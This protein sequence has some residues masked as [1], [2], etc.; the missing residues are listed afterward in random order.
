MGRVRARAASK[1]DVALKSRA[2]RQR[3]HPRRARPCRHQNHHP[4]F[5]SAP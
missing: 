4:S 5:A 2:S 1:D 3:R